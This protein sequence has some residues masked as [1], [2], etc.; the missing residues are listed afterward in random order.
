MKT[1]TLFVTLLSFLS[2]SAIAQPEW[3]ILSG[4]PQSMARYDDVF[5]L[6][7]NLGWAAD[8]GGSKVY[9]TVDGGLNWTQQFA[10]DREYYRNIEFL[11]ENIGFIGTLTAHFYKTTDGGTNWAPVPNLPNAVQAICG[12]DAVGTQTIYGCGA[13]FGP[14]YIIKSVDSGVTWQYI[15]MTAYAETLVEVLFVDENTGFAS[16][17]DPN[18]GIILKTTDG[19][20]TWTQIYNTNIP[21]EYVWKLQR[22]FSNTQVMFG[23]VETIAPRNGKLIKSVDGGISWISKEVPDPDIQAVGFITENHGWMGGHHSGFLETFD[24]GTTW[25][26]TG[27][28]FNLNRIQVFNNNLAYCSGSNIY[29]FSDENLAVANVTPVNPYRLNVKIAPNPVKD[30]LHFSVEFKAADHL[31]ISIVDN[32]GKVLKKMPSETINTAGIKNYSLPFPYKSGSYY[33]SLHYN[34]GAQAEKIIKE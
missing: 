17:G 9:K 10:T 27:L 5:F 16:G 32:Q 14:A 4:V 1:N 29:K 25:N 19:G 28:G 11:N 15:D 8:G 18:G 7:P 24:S 33:L 30:V 34:V 6:N 13:F 22:L 21:G 20:S 23:S 31:I 3:Q 2:F 12:L 26:N